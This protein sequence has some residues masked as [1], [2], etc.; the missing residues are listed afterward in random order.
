[1]QKIVSVPE[2]HDG[3][4]EQSLS[5]NNVLGPDKNM[6]YADRAQKLLI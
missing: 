1:M 4:S 6:H 5:S 3:L 2:H